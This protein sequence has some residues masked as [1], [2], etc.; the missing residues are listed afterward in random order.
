[1]LKDPKTH[2]GSYPLKPNL[3]ASLFVTITL[4][5][6]GSLASA[7][8][9]RLLIPPFGASSVLIFAFPHSPY[10]KIKSLMGGHLIASAIG[11][12]INYFFPGSL[13]A[14]AFAVGISLMVMLLTDTF[15]PAAGAD[16]I[17][18]SML[19]VG[20]EFLYAPILIGTSFLALMH[21]IHKK[22]SEKIL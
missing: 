14:T 8:D 22:L 13:M 10:A 2:L 16:P 19:N 6:L 5:I 20:P 7:T 12:S 17:L 18:I 15:H 4:L 1:M 11:I 9:L 3:L 21:V